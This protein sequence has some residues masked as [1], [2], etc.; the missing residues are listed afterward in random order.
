MVKPSPS[1]VFVLAALSIA[2]GV[3][4]I[5]M[6]SAKGDVEEARVPSDAKTFGFVEGEPRDDDASRVMGQRSVKLL[7][8]SQ[9]FK[10]PL[11]NGEVRGEPPN[12][13]RLNWSK[14]VLAIE[15]GK[16]PV[17]FLKR[18]RL[19][20]IVLATNLTE[21]EMSIPSLP[22]VAGL[23]LLDV[24]SE[25]HDFVRSL[26]HEV[27]HFVDQA[28][29]DLGGPDPVW[30]ALNPAGFRYGSGGRTLRGAW[31]SKASHEIPGFVSAY[32]TSGV[33]EDKAETFALMI[34]QRPQINE[35][36]KTDESLAAK[37]NELRIRF[38]K[39]DAETSTALF[40]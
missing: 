39:I 17:G 27:F 18:V 12:A 24:S 19:A 3:G 16:Y 13:N 26:H 30:S 10:L 7:V 36:Q 4:I 1:V 9:P 8:A 28:N 35:W 29:G 20:G 22:N 15:L 23:M 38:T 25:E 14:A 5:A 37:L 21:G 40:Y 32:A 33:E 11:P 31:A 2:T 6:K 34:T